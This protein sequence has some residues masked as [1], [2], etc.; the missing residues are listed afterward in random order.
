MATA[1]SSADDNGSSALAPA[2]DADAEESAQSRLGLQ[3]GTEF[4]LLDLTDVSEVIPVPDL[5]SVPLTKSW[6]SGVSNIRGNLVGVVDFAAFLGGT[7][8][9]L[10]DKARLVLVADKHRINSAL[11][12]SRVVGLRQFDRFER[13]ADD[14]R[15]AAWIEGRYRDRESQRWNAL[16]MQALVTHPDFLAIELHTL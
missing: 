1:P 9:T 7:P 4:W 8:V 16:N 15:L 14:P 3:L 10:D 11:V 12:F 6:F 5:L 13:E 2:Q